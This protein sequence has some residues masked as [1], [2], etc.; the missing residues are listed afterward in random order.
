MNQAIIE[1]KNNKQKDAYFYLNKINKLMPEL[2]KKY[3]IKSFG[4]FGSYIRKEETDISDIDIL[5]DF[6]QPIGLFAYIELE[7]VL[8]ENLG[9]TVDLVSKGALFGKIGQTILSEV[10]YI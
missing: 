6:D 10:V 4:I 2:R 9:V 1:K 5:V 3:P 7:T 8:S